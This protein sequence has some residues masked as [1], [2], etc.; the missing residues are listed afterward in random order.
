[1]KTLLVIACLV[2]SVAQAGNPIR[3]SE[4][5]AT[6]ADS[7]TFGAPFDAQ[8]P[9]VDLADL[10]NN[11]K[12]YEQQ[13]L[14]VE[15]PVTKVCQKKGCFFIAQQGEHTVRVAFK[16]YAFFIPTDSH[17][18]RVWLNAQLIEKNLS[19]AQAAH[20][21]ADLQQP[22]NKLASGVVYELI[23]TSVKIPR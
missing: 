15:T 2:C 18:K 1:M 16:N 23:A 9:Q 12:A 14:T 6:D 22:S 8:L 21:N 5:T 13:P 11:P 3:L 17:G 7:E 19:D 10:L 20:F 4:P